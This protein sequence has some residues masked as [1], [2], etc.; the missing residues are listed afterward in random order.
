MF[1]LDKKI[2]LIGDENCFVSEITI[3][4][5]KFGAENSSQIERNLQTIAVFLSKIQILPIFGALDFYAKEK[6]RLRK[7]GTPSDD[8]DLLIASTAVT[9]NLIMVTNNVNHFYRVQGIVIEDWTKN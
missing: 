5:L 3:A 9:N 8:F 1:D 7:Q 6:V 4:E 2:A